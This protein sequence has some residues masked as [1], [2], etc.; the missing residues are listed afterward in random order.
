MGLRRRTQEKPAAAPAA[1]MAIDSGPV[2]A[3]DGAEVGETTQRPPRHCRPAPQSSLVM[4][5]THSPFRHR[6]E[7]QSVFTEQP[8]RSHCPLTQRWPAA[9][10]VSV[11]H[12]QPSPATV[13]TAFA[14][15]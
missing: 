8:M 12:R 4:Q 9:H 15:Q 11:R 2:F 10:S 3:E 14:S 1:T 6:P 7:R 13:R 5:A